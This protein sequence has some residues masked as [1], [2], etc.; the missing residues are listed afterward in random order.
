MDIVHGL[1][2]AALVV[3][4]H[5]RIVERHH[6][7][8]LQAALEAQTPLH[9]FHQVRANTLSPKSSRYSQVIDQAA[10]AV[11]SADDRTDDTAFRVGDQ[12]QIRVASHLLLDLNQR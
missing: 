4:L 7:V 5:F 9:F 10:P 11:E 2:T 1:P 3:I 12:E 6:Q 8:T